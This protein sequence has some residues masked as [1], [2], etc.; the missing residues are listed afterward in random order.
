MGHYEEGSIML[1]YDDVI[2]TN[3]KELKGDYHD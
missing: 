3:E 2:M 1:M